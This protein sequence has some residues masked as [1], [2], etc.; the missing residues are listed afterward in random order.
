MNEHTALRQAWILFADIN[1]RFNL[2]IDECAHLQNLIFGYLDRTSAKDLGIKAAVDQEQTPTQRKWV[3]QNLRGET[4]YDLDPQERALRNLWNSLGSLASGLVTGQQRV[5]ERF[6]QLAR[7]QSPERTESGEFFWFVSLR[8]HF[9]HQ[10]F[11]FYLKQLQHAHEKL[12]QLVENM[13]GTLPGPVLM[14]RWSSGAFVDFLSSYSRHVNWQVQK[15][16]WDIAAPSDDKGFEAFEKW[17]SSQY[18]THTWS[19]VPTSFTRAHKLDLADVKDTLSFQTIWSAYFYLEQPILLPLL[20]HECAHHYVQDR[21]SQWNLPLSDQGAGTII[22]ERKRETAHLLKQMAQ[23]EVLDE[24]FWEQFVE[25]IWADMLSVFLGGRGYVAALALQIFGL[26]GSDQFSRFNTQ[27]DEMIPIDQF[28][29]P[30]RET[31]EVSWPQL[32]ND[33]L[34]E[35]RL[36]LAI[37]TYHAKYPK[38]EW[39]QALQEAI[40]KWFQSGRAAFSAETTSTEHEVY[41][42]YREQINR[43]VADTCLEALHDCYEELLPR[44]APDHT[45]FELDEAMAK[46]V[47]SNVKK[48]SENVLTKG[49]IHSRSVRQ[50]AEPFH[51]A[52]VANNKPR[53]E[54][55]C[56]SIRWYLS[57]DIAIELCH[58]PGKSSFDNLTECYASYMRNDGSAAFLLAFEW[59]RLREDLCHAAADALARRNVRGEL[60]KGVFADLTKA[61]RA[62]FREYV[63]QENRRCNKRATLSGFKTYRRNVVS[64]IHTKGH[65]VSDAWR[66]QSNFSAEKT[67]TLVQKIA[68]AA[69]EDLN[70]INKMARQICVGTLTLGVLRTTEI[71]SGLGMVGSPLVRA[72]AATRL[73][74]DNATT[75]LKEATGENWKSLT[76][77]GGEFFPLIGDYS[78]FHYLRGNTPVERDCHP[79]NTPKIVAKPRL[80]MQ[81]FG[82]PERIAPVTPVPYGRISQIRLRY[83]WQWIELVSRLS[84]GKCHC[85]PSLFLSTGWEDA[86][87]VSWHQDEHDMQEFVRVLELETSYG[88]DVHTNLIVPDLLEDAS[89]I[90]PYPNK[91]MKL[92]DYLDKCSDTHFVNR[93]TGRYDLTVV[94]GK[95]PLE[96]ARFANNLKEMPVAFWSSIGSI[97]TSFERPLKNPRNTG[98]GTTFEIVSHILLRH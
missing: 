69:I 38:D 7:M 48:Y 80:V 83:R 78:F 39:S 24:G 37:S 2:L 9:L 5:R 33:Y 20:Y 1:T 47:D 61:V 27:I 85:F 41:W 97:T 12:V 50:P 29:S 63:R 64:L 4:Y 51:L 52:Q 16:L 87:L 53:L 79:V 57:K 44:V 18:L 72:L 75:L 40:D 15:V 88:M 76:D 21:E 96:I 46:C 95:E 98:P 70:R 8:G 30:A 3:E 25:E 17:R 34:W 26:S 86:I 23:F 54:D 56:I 60:K 89:K 67:R 71:A 73:Y 91:D 94:W 68:S 93:R 59:V 22:F 6:E 42:R 82:D 55:I 31:R 92:H 11:E 74:F 32:S 58:Q 13:P 65:L 66:Y 77:F 35:A 81:V 43:W 84:V 28:G 45:L 19:H 62:D 14:R 10:A 90:E 36:M 49:L